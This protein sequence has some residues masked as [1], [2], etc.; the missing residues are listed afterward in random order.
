MFAV[1]ASLAVVSVQESLSLSR[2]FFFPRTLSPKLIISV[3]PPPIPHPP[4]SLLAGVIELIKKQ[5]AVFRAQRFDL[6]VKTVSFLAR[7]LK[8]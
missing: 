4:L 7:R 6:V 1:L 5:H 2:S 8:E 3:A